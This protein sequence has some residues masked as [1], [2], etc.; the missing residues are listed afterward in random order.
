[1]DRKR[2]LRLQWCDKREK[3]FANEKVIFCN[4]LQPLPD[5]LF[6]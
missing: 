3:E 1:M 6:K 5:P 2:I 4:L